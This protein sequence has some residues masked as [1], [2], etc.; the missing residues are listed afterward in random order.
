MRG[1]ITLFRR[2]QE[3]ATAVEFALVAPLFF[4]VVWGTVEVGMLALASSLMEGAV[5]EAARVGITG[6]S[7]SGTTRADHV[8]NA[9]KKYTTGFIDFSKLKLDTKAYASFSV[10]GQPESYVDANGNGKY[11]TGE[12]FTDTN[13]NGKWDSDQGAPGLGAA[14]EVV[15]YTITYEWAWLAGYAKDIFGVPSVTLKSTITLRNEPF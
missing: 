10:V 9:I 3:G 7:P 5:R 14:G 15:S 2:R 12:T 11:D 13:N 6:Y 8:N 4:M 1:L